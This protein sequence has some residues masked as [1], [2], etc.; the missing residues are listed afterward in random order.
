MSFCLPKFAADKLIASLPEDLSKLIDISS[1]E[2]RKFFA[3]VVGEN[4]AKE[5]NALFESK[6]LLKDQQQGI[7]NWV[8]KVTG[9]T[10]EAKRDLISRVNNMTEVL[11]PN[12]RFLSDL[13][14]KKLGVGVS[15]EEAGKIADLAKT[16]QDNNGKDA[17]GGRSLAYGKA[18]VDFHNYV[19]DLKLSAEAAKPK[20]IGTKVVDLAGI[21]KALKSTGDLSALFKQGFKILTSSPRI[22]AENGTKSISNAVKSFGDKEVMNAVNAEIISGKNY[23]RMLKGKLAVGAVE[24]AFPTPLPEKIPLFGK[25][26]R[27]SEV[28]FKSFLYKTRADLFDKYIDIAKASGLDVNNKE[29]LM[30]IADLVN[31]MTGRGD[32]GAAEPAARL[33]NNAFFSPRFTKSLFDTFTHPLGF[34]TL[35]KDVTAFQRKQA[36]INLVKQIG[37]V[38][39]IMSISNI[40]HPGSAEL[41]PDSSDFGKIKIGSTRFDITGGA[42]SLV[43]LAA[44][45]LTQS[46]KSST[47]GKISPLN[48]GKFGSQT[49]LDVV[50]SFFENK[51]SP[52][53][54]IIRD[55]LKGQTFQG[56]KPTVLNEVGNAFVPFPIQNLYS[57]NDPKAANLLLIEIADA[58]GISANTYTAA[59]KKK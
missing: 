52:I 44:R 26:F 36:G 16:V 1:E 29:E 7:I 12:D 33:V 27:S 15:I 19:N 34:D 13:V 31:S 37:A 17:E 43:T 25:V 46:T 40:V 23:E 49:E 9:I 10:P 32:L 59:P 42:G 2:R 57:N 21:T 47:T 30:G 28:G 41:N 11:Q 54:S 39:A 8:K 38:A 55:L 58:L 56:T 5:M 51:A 4:N 22:W 45:L 6:L 24:E 3:D 53:G 20:S 18:V 14:E 48:S 50:N 35:G